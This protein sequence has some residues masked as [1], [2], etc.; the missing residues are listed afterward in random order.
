MEPL[1]ISFE[2]NDE[3]LTYSREYFTN[4]LLNPK[5]RV[6]E[7]E[8]YRAHYDEQTG[9]VVVIGPDNSKIRV[10]KSDDVREPGEPIELI[11]SKH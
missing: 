6:Y 3:E 11:E 1:N 10:R 7:S 4:G 9:Q 5:I 8:S 2:F